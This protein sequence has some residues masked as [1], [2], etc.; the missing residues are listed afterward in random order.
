MRLAIPTTLLTILLSFNSFA[1][2]LYYLTENWETSTTRTRWTQS[3]VIEEKEWEFTYGGQYTSGSD[4]YYPSAPKQGSYNAGIFYEDIYLDSVKIISPELEL[5]G[6]IK[7]TLRFYHCQYN[8]PVTGPDH[9]NMYFRAGPNSSWDL[10]Q[11]WSSSIDYWKDEIF[12]ISDIDE[13]Y[14]TDTFQLAFEGVVG[15]GYG[16]YLDSITVKEEEEVERFVK[17]TTY[18]SLDYTAIP[19][20]G[21]DIPLEQIVIRV[22]GN[23]GESVLDELTIEPTGAGVSY[24]EEDGYKLYYSTEDDFSPVKG[25]TSIVIAT[26]SISDGQVTFSGFSQELALGD[27]YLWVSANFKSTLAGQTTF[28]IQVPANGISACDSVFPVS[29]VAFD[30]T[31]KIKETVYYSDFESGGA[32]WTLEGDFEVGEPAGNLVST[33]SNPENAF[34]GVNVLAT[35]LDGGYTTSVTEG[36]SDYYAYSPVLNLKYYI[37]PV[38]YFHRYIAISGQDE[39]VVEVSVDGG[40]TWET[41]WKS[42]ASNNSSYWKEF[43]DGSFDDIA[44]RQEQFQL[45]FG[46]VESLTTSW[47]GFAIDNFAIMA[48]HLTTDIG[49]TS[50]ETPYDDCLD[51][52]DKT[53]QAW[54]RNFAEEDSPDTIPVFYGLWGLDSTLVYDTIYGGIAQDDSLLFSFSELADFPRGDYYDD[55]VVGVNLSGDQDP[56]NDTLTKSLVIQ[57]SYTLPS[58]EQFEYNGGIWITQDTARWRAIDA[59]GT[60]DPVDA[61]TPVMW[62][63]SP[64]GT[65][66]ASDKSWVTS[67]CYDLSEESRNFVRFQVWTNSVYEEDGGRIEY[68]VDDGETWEILEDN[69]YNDLWN[70]MPDTVEA[71]GSK[72]WTGINEWAEAKAMIPES[73]DTYEKVKFR[74]LF[75]SDESVGYAQG[76]AFDDF[77]VAPAPHDIGVS[78]IVS[79]VAEACQGVNSSSEVDVRIVNY[80]YNTLYTGDTIVVG[81]DFQDEDPIIDTLV[82]TTDLVAG[83]SLDIS[84]SAEIAIEEDGDYE[85]YAYTL[86]EDDPYFYGTNNDTAWLDFTIWPNPDI[87][88]ADTIGS[89][90]PDTVNIVP[91]YND[92]VTGYTYNWTPGNVTDSIYDVSANGF[93]DTIY[94]IEVT[95]PEHNCVTYD[96]VN[97]LLLYYDAGADSIISPFSHCEWTDSEV[98]EILYKNTGTDSIYSD[99]SDIAHIVVGYQVDNGTVY[100]ETLEVTETMYA[101]DT[102]RF[103]FTDDPYDFSAEKSYTL[104]TWAYYE[105]GDIKR[106]N[107]T[108]TQIITTYGYTALNIGPASLTVEGLTHTLDAGSA[109][110]TYNWKQTGDTTQSIT[111]DNTLSDQS[112]LYT[113]WATDIH[114]CTSKDS[115]DLTF[116]VK[117]ITPDFILAP[118]S[119]CDNTVG[120][121][122]KIHLVNN[123]TDTIQTTDSILYTY[124]LDGESIV[125]EWEKPTTQILP[126]TQHTFTFS[127]RLDFSEERSYTLD[128]TASAA[129]DLRPANDSLNADFSITISPVVDFGTI[130]S[131]ID[132]DEYEL[133]AG[134]ESGTGPFTYLWQDGKTTQ[135]YLASEGD[136]DDDTYYVAVTDANGCVGYDTATLVFDILD[137]SVVNLSSPSSSS[138][139]VCQYA[140]LDLVVNVANMGN[141]AR[142]NISL[143]L[144]YTINESDSTEES[145]TVDDAWEDGAGNALSFTFTNPISFEESGANDL[146]VY[147]I[148]DGDMGSDNDSYSTTVTATEAPEVDFGGDTIA[149]AIPGILDPGEHD[150]YIWQDSYTGRYYTVSSSNPATYTVTVTDYDKSSCVTTE[151]VY[152]LPTAGVASYADLDLAIYPNPASDYITIEAEDLTNED[153]FIEIYSIT[154]QLIWSD[155][156]D[157][158]GT[159]TNKLDVG[160]FNDGV[161]LLRIRNE[162]VNH[163]QRFIIQK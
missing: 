126:G 137:F 85:L 96:S 62:V 51:C 117:D 21:Q 148:V 127:D 88:L 105:G 70:W 146:D 152:V 135:T 39:G 86:I 48:E 29:A 72:G 80:G 47:P 45:R 121:K 94:H 120:N 138:T 38:A 79:P 64:T 34:N 84:V 77:E 147:V 119:G 130:P 26:A 56:D 133:D 33:V 49:V 7:P 128:V 101:N 131:P 15:N 158:N 129:G 111:I 156:H 11:T 163:T 123:G 139:T 57:N 95:E 103:A 113:V 74:V 155:Y 46:I 69:I 60:I 52:T 76:F 157:G 17:K 82:L 9:L 154:N 149:L 13:K 58:V 110:E 4:N 97:V 145:F 2:D 91:V 6:A 141:K 32:D 140:D 109:F 73:V 40:S 43:Y 143:T 87:T 153:F 59:T 159:Y 99:G 161:Y 151:S 92:W 65:Y 50:I 5:G 93:G 98:I 132:G 112:G 16:V 136:N 20:G 25:D 14:L 114:N 30:N 81:V 53:V 124:Q 78:K 54:F 18:N 115:I 104:K 41:I 42:Q 36:E 23:T 100:E 122:I 102:I 118:V 24:L 89:R 28:E 35:N 44:S 125:S 61:S 162:K 68:T 144:G 75:M 134:P 63:L 83:D 106:N 67:G 22:L 90:Q 12:D 27:N 8:A 10:I 31:H 150:S 66:K 1:E 71:L 37:N 19:A 160:G 142:S 108:I 116:L 3:P 107:D 55:F